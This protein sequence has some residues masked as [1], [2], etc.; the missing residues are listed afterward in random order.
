MCL[1][2]VISSLFS[3]NTKTTS[4][5]DPRLAKKAKPPEECKENGRLLS[6][7]VFFFQQCTLRMFV[8]SEERFL[9]KEAMVWLKPSLNVVFPAGETGLVPCAGH[10][11]ACPSE[12]TLPSISSLSF[13]RVLFE[14][15]PD[16]L[17]PTKDV[18]C[19]V[20]LPEDSGLSLKSERTQRNA[21]L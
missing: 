8:N 3:H 14:L 20:C 7:Y 10:V 16:F 12:E 5:L 18:R 6:F 1:F 21:I 11:F 13:L 17:P 15:R 9:C 4:W 2:R 19:A